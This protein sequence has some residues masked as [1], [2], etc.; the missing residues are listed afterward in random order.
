MK[1]LY[2]ES[3]SNLCLTCGEAVSGGE[4]ATGHRTHSNSEGVAGTC[5]CDS[6]NNWI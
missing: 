4:K 2:D 3:L 6:A 5:L 1:H